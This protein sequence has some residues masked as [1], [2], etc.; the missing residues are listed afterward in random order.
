MFV[1]E[2]NVYIQVRLVVYIATCTLYIHVC[3]CY[4]WP[5]LLVH[6]LKKLASLRIGDQYEVTKIME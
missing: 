2:A 6:L 4:S 1:M 3:A 5:A